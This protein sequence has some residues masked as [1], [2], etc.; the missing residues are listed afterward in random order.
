MDDAC[1]YLRQHVHV[2][3]ELGW[4]WAS[5]YILEPKARFCARATKAPKSWVISAVPLLPSSSL[6]FLMF[7][8]F[9]L[10]TAL[11][12]YCFLTQVKFQ[13]DLSFFFCRYN[14][15]AISLTHV[16]VYSSRYPWPLSLTA[17]VDSV[18]YITLVDSMDKVQQVLHI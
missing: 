4:L 18:Y 2:E 1:M 12:G 15:C 10:F 16:S 5:M 9:L 11:Q 6:T 8:S 17:W 3:L 14:I 7:Y 13:V